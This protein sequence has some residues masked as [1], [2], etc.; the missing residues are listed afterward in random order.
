MPKIYKQHC[1]VCGL[2]YEGVSKKCCSIKCAGVLRRGH[3]SYN[4]I[5]L[6]DGSWYPS[7]PSICKCSYHCNEIVYNGKEYIH[8]HNGRGSD[9]LMYG[10][11]GELSPSFRIIRTD[12]TRERLR[13]ANTGKIWSDFRK[14]EWSEKRMGKGNP[15]FGFKDSKE[16]KNIK[17]KQKKGKLNPRYGKPSPDGAGHCKRYYYESE[18]HGIICFKGSYE[19]KY[20]LYL[21]INKISWLYQPKTF[22][23]SDEMTY[24]PDFY[25]SSEDKYIETK[26]YLY[27]EHKIKIEKFLKEYPN[28]KLEILYKHDLEKLGIDMKIKLDQNLYLK[29]KQKLLKRKK[30]LVESSSA[31]CMSGGVL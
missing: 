30:S 24:T 22:P 9:N 25:L 16:T 27:P 7:I 23:L 6:S 28:L 18:T 13:I 8:G 1:S 5:T 29:G 4:R 21:D 31:Q 26:G 17:S 20:V 3:I 14:K 12:E 19:Y 10:K 15:H 11:S 2:Y